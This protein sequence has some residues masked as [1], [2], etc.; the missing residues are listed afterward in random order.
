MSIHTQNNN[1]EYLHDGRKETKSCLSFCSSNDSISQKTGS[2]W[3]ISAFLIVNAS[4]GSGLLNYPIAFYQA[5]GILTAVIVQSFFLVFVVLTLLT[6][7]YCSDIKGSNTYQD[8]VLSLC[9]RKAQLACAVCVLLYSLGTCITYLI[10][11]GDQWE[12]L[13]LNVAYD[14][15]C[16]TAPVYMT[17]A[18]VISATSI[19]FILPLCFPRRIDFLRYTSIIGVLG[20]LYVVGLIAAKYFLPHENP[21][22]I[23]QGPH[24]WM[25]IFL[26]VPN[27]CFAY[28]CHISIIPVYSCLD[29]RDLREFSKTV[30]LAMILCVLIYTVTAALGYLQFGDSI[31][32]DILLSFNPTA[33][34]M[35]AVVFVVVKAYTTYPIHCFCGKAAFDT[36]WKMVWHMSPEEIIHRENNRHIATTCVW[37]T[38]TL[39]LSIFIP[40]IGVVIQILGA[41]AAVFIFVFPGLCLFKVTQTKIDFEEKQPTQ[42]YV[43]RAMAIVFLIVG[44]FIFGLT[45]SQ[46]VIKDIQGVKPDSSKFTCR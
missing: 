43:L 10:L 42:I 34:V 20:L 22:A 19:A 45:L 37:F 39:L 32:N 36:V 13:F 1:F 11:I 33:A 15:Y 41:L 40:N 25:D 4:I 12:L 14:F 31:T 2:G 16:S 30:T 46:A 6:L 9:G 28:Q 44:V 3:F 27:I 5:G 35:V 24:T 17:R 21:G 7:G 18:F 38:L 23:I 8:V 29:K 26:A